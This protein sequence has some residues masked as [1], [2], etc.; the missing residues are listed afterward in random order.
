MIIFVS[1][2]S[3]VE[4]EFRYNKA[5][6]RRR[7]LMLGQSAFAATTSTVLLNLITPAYAQTGD[8]PDW[9]F[10]SKCYGMFYNGTPDKGHC[11]TG[12]GHVP[13]GFLFQLHYDSNQAGTHQL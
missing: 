13:Q 6:S 9:R 5:L 4:S 8:Q 11:S 1:K 10:C 3:L 12:G 7:M 2:E